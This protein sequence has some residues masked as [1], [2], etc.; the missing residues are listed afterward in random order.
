MSAARRPV[1]L[2]VGGGVGAEI[3]PH[4][5][6]LLAAVDAPVEWRRVEVSPA[7]P[8]SGAELL[9]EAVAAIESCGLALKTKLVGAGVERR[10]DRQQKR[11]SNPQIGNPNVQLRLRLD[12]FA[13]VRPIRSLAGLATRYPD[14]DL[15]LVREST[16]D[17][18]KG[19]EHVIVDGVVQSLKVVTRA[20]CERV[21]RFAFEI[22]TERKRKRLTFVH[23]G[24]IMKRSDGLFLETVRGVAADFPQIELREMIVDAACMQMVLDPYQFD[25]VLTGNLYG[26][27]L[28]SLGSGLAGGISNA[29]SINIGATC[30]V[31]EAI[32]GDAPDLVGRGIAN[33]LPVLSPALSLLR[34]LGRHDLSQRLLDAIAGVL[35]EGRD[36]TPD[37]GGTAD[38]TTMCRAIRARL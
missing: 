22:A 23:K 4:V 33:P 32:H 15:L 35:R 27:I 9:D 18:Y 1:A 16:E 21:S 34:H 12:L 24:N 7:G 5:L 10:P 6:E 14:L 13:G 29:H 2:I 17:I 20:G 8:D 11:W 37:L 25:V 26:D 19:I 3:L 36:V 38:T 30:R 28:S 31:F